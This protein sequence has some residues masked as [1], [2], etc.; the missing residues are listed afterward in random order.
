MSTLVRCPEFIVLSTGCPRV[1]VQTLCLA[2]QGLDGDP[3]YLLDE[4]MCYRFKL[5]QDGDGFFKLCAG[6]NIL[7]AARKVSGGRRELREHATAFVSR[8]TQARRVRVTQRVPDRGKML[9]NAR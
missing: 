4:F 5:F 3:V 1:F 2:A 9:R 7:Q 6:R 8:F